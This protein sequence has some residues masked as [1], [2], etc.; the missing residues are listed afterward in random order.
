MSVVLKCSVQE[1]EDALKA[2]ADRYPRA[3]NYRLQIFD[4]MNQTGYIPVVDG[5][6][7]FV[8]KNDRTVPV[9]ANYGV[10][11]A[12]ASVMY[13]AL[14]HCYEMR[15]EDYTRHEIGMVATVHDEIILATNRKLVEPAKQILEAAMVQ[16]WLDVFPGTDTHNLV[17]AKDGPNWGEAK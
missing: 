7:I 14:H 15:S 13:R 1:A 17:E 12:A 8:Y 5:R 16:G 6:Q 4:R 3:Y 9:A 2:W 11:G 10:Q